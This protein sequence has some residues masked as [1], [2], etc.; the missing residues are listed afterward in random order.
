[1]CPFAVEAELGATAEELH[2]PVTGELV[3]LHFKVTRCHKERQ[4]HLGAAAS[5]TQL[6]QAWLAAG[7]PA[8]MQK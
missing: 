5:Q 2:R 1:M 8:L 3:I 4:C 7:G 6:R